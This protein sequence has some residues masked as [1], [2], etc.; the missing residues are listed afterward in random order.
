[1]LAIVVAIPRRDMRSLNIRDVASAEKFRGVSSH[2]GA[3][4]HGMNQY[5]QMY[6]MCPAR[7]DGKA[8]GTCVLAIAEEVTL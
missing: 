2:A 7:K 1:M 5:S 3:H 6:V 8:I 4:G